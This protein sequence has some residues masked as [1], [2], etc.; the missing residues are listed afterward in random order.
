MK[1]SEKPGFYSKFSKLFRK[2][3]FRSKFSRN[4]GFGQNF[5][6]CRFGSQF[7]ISRFGSKFSKILILVTIVEMSQIWSKLSKILDF[8]QNFK[9]CRFGSKDK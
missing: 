4:L 1:I 6:K 2:Y 3:Q 9:K 8:G 5:E 7:A